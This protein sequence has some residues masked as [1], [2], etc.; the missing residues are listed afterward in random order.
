MFE[1]FQ[2]G[3]DC[4]QHWIKKLFEW[5]RWLLSTLD[6]KVVWMVALT[7]F[8][9]G[10]KSCLNG[11]VDCF[12]HWIKKLFEWWRRLLSTL[13]QKVVWMVASQLSISYDK[14]IR[15]VL[16]M[17]TSNWKYTMEIPYTQLLQT[18]YI[19]TLWFFIWSYLYEH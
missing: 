4:F 15:I 14:I 17:A 3:V 10:S 12:Q 9:I 8:N 16:H 5:W 6:Q 18:Q 11:G 7:A 1:C 2:H 13:D 19:H